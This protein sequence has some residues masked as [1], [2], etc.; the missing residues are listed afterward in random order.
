MSPFFLGANLLNHDEGVTGYE[1]SFQISILCAA[2]FYLLL[3]LVFLRKLLFLYAIRP[4]V[5]L[6]TQFVLVFATN[7][8]YYATEEPSFSHIYSLFAITAFLYV[9]KLFF[10]HHKSSHLLW[11][12]VLLGLIFIL[13]P[14]NV[15]IVLFIPFIAGSFQELQTGIKEVRLKLF[16]SAALLFV[17]V[18]SMQLI[19]WYVQTGSWFVYSYG[20]ES[21]DFSDPHFLEILFSFRKG[22]FVYTPVLFLSMFTLLYFIR[23]KTWYPLCAFIFAFVLLTYVLSSWHDWAYGFSYGLR[24]FIEFFPLFFILIALLL[25]ERSRWMK[26]IYLPMGL[27]VVLNLV[28]TWQYKKYILHWYTMDYTTYKKVFLRTSAAYKG[29][30]WKAEFH[31]GDFKQD[32]AIAFLQIVV[33]ENMF[34]DTVLYNPISGL[35]DSANPEVVNI[36][37]EHNFPSYNETL[38]ELNIMRSRDQV[39]FTR[40]VPLIHFA[41]DELNTQQRGHYWFDVS[42]VSMEPTDYLM[43][44]I[45][46][47]GKKEILDKMEIQVYHQ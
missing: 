45:F 12:A 11:C 36:S 42:G 41:S 20:N 30:L 4:A 9:A 35:C 34:V 31:E 19:L 8:L 26:L 18:I 1:D 29:I 40:N 37:F 33:T 25:N 27:F 5:I 28:Q 2:L 14:V 32:T 3:T 46:T 47:G 15:L 10:T 21:F 24:A 43:V 6:A 44:R 17:G 13:R 7:V 16:L 22:L 39:L 38:I 23:R